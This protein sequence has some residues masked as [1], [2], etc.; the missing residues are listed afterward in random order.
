MELRAR[1]EPH[2]EAQAGDVHEA[3]LAQVEHHGTAAV[4]QDGVHAAFQRGHGGAVE[5][6][7]HLDQRGLPDTLRAVL[8]RSIRTR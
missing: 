2:R 8:N 1:L 7:V 4:V 6:T 5:L 3:Q